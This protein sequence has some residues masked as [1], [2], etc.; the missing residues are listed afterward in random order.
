MTVGTCRVRGLLL[1]NGVVLLFN[2]VVDV[3]VSVIVIGVGLP[4]ERVLAVGIVVSKSSGKD[5][6]DD[7]DDAAGRDE[8]GN[9]AE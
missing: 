5:V 6:D 4:K 8:A 1:P 3:A 9:G 7:N 2:S